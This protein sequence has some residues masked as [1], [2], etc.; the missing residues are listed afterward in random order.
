MICP[1]LLTPKYLFFN[2]DTPTLVYYAHLSSFLVA[3]LIGLFV[4]FKNKSLLIGKVLL[5]IALV[6]SLHITSSLLM[7]TTNGS[8]L[9][10]F[11]WSLYGITQV[12]L[13]YLAIY[14]FY[15]FTDQK[16]ISFNKKLLLGVLF[17]PIILLAPAEYNLREF[18]ISSCLA[19]EQGNYFF[20]YF[21]VLF[22]GSFLWVLI[23]AFSKYR[24]IKK[25]RKTQFILMTLGIEFFLLAFF[26][27]NILDTY[28]VMYGITA[29]YYTEQYGLFG[30]AAFMGIIA[31]LATR[32]KA[33]NIKFVGV[34]L[35]IISLMIIIGIQIFL[36]ENFADKVM[37]AITFFFLL[38]FG[39]FTI[40][41][42]VEIRKKEELE[43]L[44]ERLKAANDELIRLD[45]AKSEFITI[46]SHKLR[47]PM[48][49]IKGFASMLLE[50][51]YGEIDE[52]PKDVINKIYL[53]NGRLIHLAEDLLNVSQIESGK[54]EYNYEK[55]NLEK[56]AEEAI[57][58][59]LIRA[60][61]KGI[62]LELK[63]PDSPFPEIITDKVKIKEVIFY[64][65]DN[66]IKYT[67]KGGVI[68]KLSEEDSFVRISVWDTGIGIS[69]EEAPSLFAKFARGKD[70]SLLNT[71]G[72]GLS[73][74]V[75]RNIMQALGGKIAFSSE[76]KGKGSTFMIDVPVKIE[77]GKKV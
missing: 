77:K 11:L 62:T 26:A 51:S 68:V 52:K 42:R 32:Y 66:A 47:T 33:S 17:L 57:D 58:T 48:T 61:E 75:A 21:E 43:K 35:L 69:K 39:W 59:F 37:S 12:L 8:G 22:V 65:I 29:D 70:V 67:Q 25:E 44:A 1:E 45:I 36:M 24:K 46:A 76:G 49:A 7:W 40:A 55:V 15:V 73:L 53:S 3:L 9:I 5:A 54:V 27:T 4:Y 74:H 34:Q 10:F 19:L 56:I 31:Y 20:H 30:M 28:L 16:D 38:L 41:I 2:E 14:F 71:E 23:A 13:C 63:H 6:F 64:I 18:D 50:G 60:K 72:N